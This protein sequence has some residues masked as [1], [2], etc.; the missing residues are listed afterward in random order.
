MSTPLSGLKVIELTRI[1]AALGLVKRL[2]ILVR[3][4]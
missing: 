2:L 4:F 3:I 1:L